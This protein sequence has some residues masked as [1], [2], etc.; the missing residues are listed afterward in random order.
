MDD[1]AL[2]IKEIMKGGPLAR[3]GSIKVGTKIVGVGQGTRLMGLLAAE[4]KSYVSTIAFG[5]STNTDDAEGAVVR[6]LGYEEPSRPQQLSPAASTFYWD[7]RLSTGES[8]PPGTYT[9]QVRVR[10]GEK[11]FLAESNPFQLMEESGME[12]K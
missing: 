4:T 12:Q 6:R 1:G 10:L 9:A 2:E 8:A 5:A 3:E 7:G 11:T